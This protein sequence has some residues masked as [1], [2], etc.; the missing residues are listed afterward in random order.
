VKAC[1]YCEVVDIC[2]QARNL[3]NQGRLVVWI[4]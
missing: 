4:F 3:I 2:K 1:R